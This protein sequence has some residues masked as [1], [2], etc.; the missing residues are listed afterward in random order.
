MVLFGPS[1]SSAVLLGPSG[2]FWTGQV[3]QSSELGK[4]V[5]SAVHS[6]HRGLETEGDQARATYSWRQ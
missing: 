1:G 6:H 3:G 4:H 5:L 2:Y